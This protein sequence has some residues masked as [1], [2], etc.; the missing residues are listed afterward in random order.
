M[1]ESKDLHIIYGL[2]IVCISGYYS[3]PNPNPTSNSNCLYIHRH[4]LQHNFSGTSYAVF[5]RGMKVRSKMRRNVK[6]IH[7]SVKKKEKR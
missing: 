2:G 4:G 1:S 6:T 5:C 7:S 3:N